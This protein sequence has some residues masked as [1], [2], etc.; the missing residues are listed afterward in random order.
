ME[1]NNI[2]QSLNL[3]F[4]KTEPITIDKKRAGGKYI[5]WGEDNRLPQQLF[6]L[7][8]NCSELQALVNTLQDYIC[9]NGIN[10]D[11]KY[12]SDDGNSFSEELT[13][14]ILDY[15]IFGGFT[16]ECLRNAN[17]DI[18]QI[19]YQ[20]VM[21]VRVDNDL[22]TAYICN[23]WG[24]WNGKDILELPLFDKSQKQPHFIYYYRGN[25]TRN[26]NPIPIWFSS[27]KSA[28]VLNEVR[29]FN[30]NNIQNNFTSNCIVTLNGAQVKS[31]ELQE[32][33][34]K[35][36]SEYT[37]AENAGKVLFI[38]N[39]NTDGKVEVTRLNPDNQVDLYNAVQENATNDLYTGFRLN[40]MLIGNNLQTGFA[41]QDYENAYKLTYE[42][43]IKPLQK[44]ISKAVKHLG[45][46]IEFN[47]FII[48]WGEQ[49][50]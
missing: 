26:I 3:N 31:K 17:G 1:D 41:T 35:L 16:L 24:R 15:I 21:N 19:N 12:L 22:T 33:K 38:N 39:T 30:L 20:N 48:D 2:I 42:T 47:P 13:K 5:S 4:S 32:V 36:N 18:T 44:N 34:D 10:S 45:I 29:K 50:G 43:V 6:D 37:G 25:I 28:Q 11:F 7:Y 40:K 14:C 27:I 46:E 49:K 8:L 23:D 9:G